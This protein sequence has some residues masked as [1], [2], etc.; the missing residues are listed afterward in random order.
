[1][2]IQHKFRTRHMLESRVFQ[3]VHKTVALIWLP[4]VN[5]ATDFC[6]GWVIFWLLGRKLP[7]LILLI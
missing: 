7:Y 3:R 1:M 4:P 2:Y 6:L 5:W